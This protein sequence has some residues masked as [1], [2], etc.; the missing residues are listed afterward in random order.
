MK[1]LHR[2]DLLCWSVFNEERNLDF[3][4]VLWHRPSGNVAIDP[5]PL[6]VHDERHL[7]ELGGVRTIIVTN[8]DHLRSSVAL[9]KTTGADLWGPAQ[10]ASMLSECGMKAL[11]E[12]ARSIEGVEIYELDGSKTPGELA[13]RL[14]GATLFFGDLVRG[15]RAGK[16]NL[17]PDP[18]LSDKRQAVTSVERMAELSGTEAVLVGDG[19]P[20]F[21]DGQRALQEL[22]R[23]LH[24][25]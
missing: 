17:L 22:V 11:S 5:L 13:L 20:V 9:G 12:G 21:R 10:E 2:P 7:Q 8:S 15:H 6:S 1:T 25:G 19:W 4:S 23:E 24:Q 18:K 16:L 3:H 14:D